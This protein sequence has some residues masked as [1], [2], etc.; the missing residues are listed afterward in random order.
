[1][2]HVCLAAAHT[3]HVH[4]ENAWVAHIAAVGDV[5]AIVR[6]STEAVNGLRGV[7]ELAQ[8]LPVAGQQKQLRALIAPDIR[9]E[10]HLVGD[11]RVRHVEDTLLEKG[12]LLGPRGG[13]S[14]RRHIDGP[15]LIRARDIGQE[16]QALAIGSKVP[17]MALRTLR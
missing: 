3:H 15:G 1:V 13:L 7:G 10:D 11:R 2:H 12:Q 5:P 14:G 8:V 9:T 17:A 6:P 16:G 4:I